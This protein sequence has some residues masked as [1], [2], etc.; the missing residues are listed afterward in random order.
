[1]KEQFQKAIDHLQ[2]ELMTVRTGRATPAMVE[3]VQVE[4]YGA[5]QP[6]KAVATI[7]TPD[8]RT[9]QMEPW[10]ASVVPAI[11]SALM[12]AD[13]GM[14]PT[15]DGKTIRL[16][17]PMMTDEGR[18]KMVKVVKEKME[19]ARIAIRQVREEARKNI[20][21]EELSDDEKK[22]AKDDLEKVVK[23]FNEKVDHMGKAKEAEVTTI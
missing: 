16:N 13:L 21:K 18:Q 17:V 7:T 6:L 19:Y 2:D 11:E 3:G 9:I 4:A 14:T 1:M 15:V 22:R 20:D 10:D 23:E 12:K 8:A 5:L